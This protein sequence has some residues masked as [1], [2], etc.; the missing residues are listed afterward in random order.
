MSG[1]SILRILVIVAVAA[2]V[3]GG[4]SRLYRRP[5]RPL[6]DGMQYV[7]WALHACYGLNHAGEQ[8]TTVKAGDKQ[9]TSRVA[10]AYRRPG[11][12]HLRYLGGPL[13]GVQVWEDLHRVYR[14]LPDKDRLEVAPDEPK[15]PRQLE[16]RLDLMQKNY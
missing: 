1:R 3:A 16:Q 7:S 13:H 12:R 15:D 11:M 4:A 14:Y 2:A 9:F 6:P 10:I 8:T 5:Q